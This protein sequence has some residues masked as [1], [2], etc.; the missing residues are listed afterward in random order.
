[1]IEMADGSSKEIT[2]IQLEDYTKGGKVLAT[3]QGVPQA[4][5][6][7]KDVKVTGSHLVKE[8]GLWTEVENSKHGVLTDMIEPVYTLIT[9]DNR[10]FIKG[11]EFGDYLQ[12]SDEEWQPY[13]KMMKTNL[14]KGVRKVA[15]G[16]GPYA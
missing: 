10:I 12:I 11:I 1:M 4:I 15:T 6:D 5:Y 3:L 7:Y 9:S 8:E 14:N 2:T 13:Y 16:E